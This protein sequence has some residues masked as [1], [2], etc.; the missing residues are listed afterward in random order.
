MNP[1]ETLTMTFLN[2]EGM[3]AWVPGETSV[4]EKTVRFCPIVMHQ[5]YITENGREWTG[6]AEVSK[7]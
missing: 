3:F 1:M 5:I 4:P 2:G 6:T 7:Q